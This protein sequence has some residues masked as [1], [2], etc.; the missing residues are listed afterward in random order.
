MQDVTLASSS[1]SL[2]SLTGIPHSVQEPRY[3]KP[4]PKCFRPPFALAPMSP[5]GSPKIVGLPP[6]P[7]CSLP[8]YCSYNASSKSRGAVAAFAEPKPG[9][10]EARFCLIGL[11]ATCTLDICGAFCTKPRV[12]PSSFPGCLFG[13]AVCILQAKAL[14]NL[15]PHP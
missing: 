13:A 1:M 7:T 12:L 5:C 15:L 4:D 11:P 2:A 8:P 10:R 9:K 14:A 3:R 6:L